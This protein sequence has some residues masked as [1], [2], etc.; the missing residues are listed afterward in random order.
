MVI[1]LMA[2]ILPINWC[3]ISSINSIMA[4]K[5]TFQRQKCPPWLGFHTYT[6][7]RHLK[8]GRLEQLQLGSKVVMECH[9]LEC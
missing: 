4:T 1:L 7:S 5:G 8:E 9:Q 6:D 3:R 2:E